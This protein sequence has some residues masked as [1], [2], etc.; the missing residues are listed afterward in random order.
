M[1]GTSFTTQWAGSYGSYYPMQDPYSMALSY[2]YNQLNW[3]KIE[4]MNQAVLAANDQVFRV[5]KAL[6]HMKQIHR[7]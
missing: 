5:S 7:C 2:Q 1:D 3:E 6:S 4:K